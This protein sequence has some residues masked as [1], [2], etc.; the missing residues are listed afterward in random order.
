MK[1]NKKNILNIV[2]KILSTI[3]FI[4][5]LVFSINEIFVYIEDFNF[6][7]NFYD[8]EKLADAYKQTFYY[9]IHCILSLFIAFFLFLLVN[10]KGLKFLTNSL[11]EQIKE[12]RE[13]TAE[14]RKTKKQ[15]KLQAEIAQKQAEL[16]EMKNE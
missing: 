5:F 15:A 10:F 1:S 2:V 7:R 12:H 11:I 4:Y 9:M 3:F 8:G 6:I 14:E 13:K 16:E